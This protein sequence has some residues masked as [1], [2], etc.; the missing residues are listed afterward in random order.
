MQPNS[1]VVVSLHSPKEKFWGEG[2]RDLHRRSY[3]ARR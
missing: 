1:I 3:A 2:G